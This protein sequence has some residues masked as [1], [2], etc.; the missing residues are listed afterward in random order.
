MKPKIGFMGQLTTQN[1]LDDL[2]FA[3]KNGFD[4]FEIG[5]DWKRNYNLKP[6]VI[7]KIKEISQENKIRLIVHT[8]FYLPTSTMLPEIKKGVIEN[9]GKAIIF[10]NKVG[11]DRLTIHSG[12]REMPR[13]ANIRLCYDSLIENL[14]EIVKIGKQYKINICLENSNK[15]TLLLCSERKDFL[16]VLNQVKGLKATLDVGHANTTNIK[17]AQYFNGVKNFIM[18]MHVHDNNG[19]SDEHKCLGGGNV[20]FQKL[21]FKCKKENYFGPFI[22]EVF[23]YKNILKGKKILSDIWGKS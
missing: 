8:P 20:D 11:S 17:P 4:W 5:L 6:E 13:R 21:F 14:R 1:V 9:A 16:N 2:N 22:L 3:V 7:K 19:K 12:Y 15:H 18:D 23:P 10:A